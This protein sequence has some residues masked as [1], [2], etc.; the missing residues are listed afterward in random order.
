VAEEKQFRFS[1]GRQQRQHVAHQA[2]G[3]AVPELGVSH[4]GETAV[5]AGHPV[6]FG[7]SIA[8]LLVR[9]GGGGGQAVDGFY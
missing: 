8:E 7:Q 6:G 4:N 3:A 9:V 1:V 2:A 5:P